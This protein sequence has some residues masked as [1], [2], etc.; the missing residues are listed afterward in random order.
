MGLSLPSW[1]NDTQTEGVNHVETRY[2]ILPL[3]PNTSV[4]IT[5]RVEMRFRGK[6]LFGRVVLDC[7]SADFTRDGKFIN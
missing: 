7:K 1:A 4:P 5:V 6:N 2:A 3:V